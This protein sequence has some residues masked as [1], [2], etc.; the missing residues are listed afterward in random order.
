MFDWILGGEPDEKVGH[1]GSLAT[2]HADTPLMAFETIGSLLKQRL[3]TFHGVFHDS[4][5]L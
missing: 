1:A 2:I 3:V 4:T 5:I